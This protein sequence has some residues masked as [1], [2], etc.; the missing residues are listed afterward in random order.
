MV[1]QE[2][3]RRTLGVYQQLY[4]N[5]GEKRLS[6]LG[7]QVPEGV[8]KSTPQF[9]NA[10]APLLQKIDEESQALKP[11]DPFKKSIDNTLVTYEKAKRA[12][13]EAG[14]QQQLTTLLTAIEQQKQARKQNI[15]KSIINNSKGLRPKTIG[16]FLFGDTNSPTGRGILNIGGFLDKE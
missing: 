13:D 6:E 10:V 7:F 16:S 1:Q 2:V 11:G 5:L 8:D 14:A 12:G 4:D 9:R 15:N 3:A